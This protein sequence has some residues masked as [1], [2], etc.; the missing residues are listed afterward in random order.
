[1][2]N[3][4]AAPGSYLGMDPA[5]LVWIP[6]IDDG[7][8]IEEIEEDNEPYYEEILPR[9][10]EVNSSTSA[11]V[12]E[13]SENSSTNSKDENKNIKRDEVSKILPNELNQDA[14]TVNN[15]KSTKRST[16]NE[17][18]STKK[19]PVVESIQMHELSTNNR[20]NYNNTKFIS[21]VRVHSRKIND[22]KEKETSV[23]KSPSD[24]DLNEYYELDDIQFV[25]DEDNR[26]TINYVAQN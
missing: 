1:M 8:I 17:Y 7:N 19:Q 15:D 2:I 3:A 22:A 9:Q 14:S 16:T 5:Y 6:P 12:S 21:P 26:E 13:C 11:N 10:I 23:V 20:R 18:Q 24:S 25:D 4:G